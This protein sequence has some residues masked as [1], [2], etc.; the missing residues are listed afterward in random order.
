MLDFTPDG[1]DGLSQI[2]RYLG[3]TALVVLGISIGVGALYF[4]AGRSG[5]VSKTQEKGIRMV[6][7][8]LAS[9]TVLSSV[10]AGIAWGLSQGGANLMP[11]GS[12]QQDVTVERQESRVSCPSRGEW[13]AEDH[14][15]A[16]GSSYPTE[17]ASMEGREMLDALGL[18]EAYESRLNDIWDD[19]YD[20][21]DP[22]N[23]PIDRVRVK[24]VRWDP[25]G[26]AGECD[27]S[28]H[29]L[30]PGTEVDIEAV[31]YPTSIQER[32]LSIPAEEAQ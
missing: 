29:N 25:D 21:A 32:D 28:N 18:L 16:I 26:T 17:S 7:I 8:G 12:Q 5:G 10:S 23:R 24:S 4:A 13:E 31:Q 1:L 2:A 27:S 20:G 19:E 15:G 3:G 14:E 22:D 9:V 30:M 11:E 6:L